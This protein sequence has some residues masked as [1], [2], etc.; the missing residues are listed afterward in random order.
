MVVY[1]VTAAKVMKRADGKVQSEDSCTVGH[2]MVKCSYMYVLQNLSRCEE[3][4]KVFRGIKI[5]KES[6]NITVHSHLQ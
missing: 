2:S 3:N 6:G 5:G 1:C 4:E